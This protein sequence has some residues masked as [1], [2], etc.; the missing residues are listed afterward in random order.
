MFCGSKIVSQCKIGLVLVEKCI[1]LG[2]PAVNN[3][4]IYMKIIVK[5]E[6]TINLQDLGAN[7]QTGQVTDGNGN[8]GLRFTT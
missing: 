6:Q 5:G 1:W 3:Y 4:L 2:T 7:G 8:S